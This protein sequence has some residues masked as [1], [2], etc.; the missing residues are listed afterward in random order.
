MLKTQFEWAVLIVVVALLGGA[1]IVVSRDVTA[2]SSP[3]TLA[4]A[5][6]VGHRAPDFTLADSVG[7]SVAL[8]DYVN[9]TEGQGRPVVLNFWA[10]WCAPCR[11]EMPYFQNASRKYDG[12]VAI[13]GINQGESAQ[14]VR[15]FGNEFKI[16]YPLLI[17]ADSSVNRLYNV[18]GLPTTVFIDA[19]GVVREVVIGT[20][21]QAVLED[22]IEQL[23]Q[24]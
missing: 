7:Q 11:I 21:N 1:W 3:T 18:I 22:R 13:V 6:I 15:D 8:N 20:I 14:M 2:E 17:D 4:E 12:R 9:P 24:K 5:P 16:S 23:L 19:S 10:T